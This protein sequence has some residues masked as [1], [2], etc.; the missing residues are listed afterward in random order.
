MAGELGAALSAHVR[1]LLQGLSEQNFSATAQQIMQLTDTYGPEGAVLCIRGLAGGITFAQNNA[2][3]VQLLGLLVGRLAERPSFGSVLAQGLSYAVP[4]PD[5]GFLQ[6]FCRVCKVSPQLSVQVAAALADAAESGDWRAEGERVLRE[7]LPGLNGAALASLGERPLHALLTFLRSSE[8][9]RGYLSQAIAVLQ[10]HYGRGTVPALLRPLLYEDHSHSQPSLGDWFQSGQPMSTE[11]VVA[12]L[13][14]TTDQ[15]TVIEELGYACTTSKAAFAEVLGLMPALDERALGRLVG[16][17]ARTHAELTR[18][19]VVAGSGVVGSGGS[20]ATYSLLLMALRARAPQDEPPQPSGWNLDVIVEVVKELAPTLSWARAMVDHLDQERFHLPDQGAFLTLISLYKRATSEPFPVTAVAG[21]LWQNSAGQLSLLNHAVAAPPDVFSWAQSPTKQQPLEGLHG[22]KNPAGTVNQAWLSLDLIQTLAMLAENSGMAADVRAL[23]EHPI[24]HC[25]ELLLLGIA[26]TRTEWNVLQGEVFQALVPQYLANHPNSSLVLHQLFPVNRGAVLRAM[27][28]AHAVDPTSLPRVLE[29]CQDLKQLTAVLDGAPFAFALDLASLA[30]RREYLNLEKWLSERLAAQGASFASACIQFLRSKSVPR[31]SGAGSTTAPAINLSRETLS[32]F[33]AVLSRGGML[34][35]EMQEELKIHQQQASAGNPAAGMGAGDP[36]TAAPQPEAM[37]FSPDIEEEANSFFQKVYTSQQSIAEAVEMLQVFSNGSPR[38]QEVFSCMIHNLFDE[39]R[40]FP[41]YPDKELR[42]TA[43]LF[44]S[45]INH[46]LLPNLTLGIALRYVLDALRKPVG[47]KMFVFG[48]EALEEF[49]SRLLEWPPFCQHLIAI[50]HM[51]ESHPQVVAFLERSLSTTS[52]GG[53]SDIAAVAATAAA[54]ASGGMGSAYEAPDAASIEGRSA[55][56]AFSTNPSVG[57]VQRDQG[58]PPQPPTSEMQRLG[59][60][61]GPSPHAAP[62]QPGAAAGSSDN[63]SGMTG[64]SPSRSGSAAGTSP[65]TLAGQAGVGALTPTALKLD[66]AASPAPPAPQS[67]TSVFTSLNIDTLLQAPENSHALAPGDALVDKVAFL[68]NNLSSQNLAQKAQAVRDLI[69]EEHFSWFATYLVVKRVSLEGN[70]HSLYLGLLDELSIRELNKQVLQAAYRNARILLRSDKI[71][72]S[73]AERSL[74]K[75]LGA[76][77]GNLTIAKNKPVLQR[78]LD[79]KELLFEAY[80]HGRMI[81][82]MPF[83]AKIIEPCKDSK[84]FAPPNPWLMAV[85]A[86]LAEIY[87]EK[88]LKLNLKF[89]VERLFKHLEVDLKTT[90]PS[91][92]LVHRQR[93][94]AIDNQDF[95]QEKRAA[96]AVSLRPAVVPSAAAGG[97][98]VDLQAPVGA[99]AQQ[100]AGAQQSGV[101]SQQPPQQQ[102]QQPQQPQQQSGLSPPV[103]PSGQPVAK[104]EESPAV[105]P[106]PQQQTQTTPS[107]VGYEQQ[108]LSNVQQYVITINQS[109]SVLAD[110]LQLKRLLPVALD[111]G[112]REIVS[113]VVERSVTIAC[114]TTRELVL[115]DFAVDPDEARLRKAAHL[116]VSSL[117]GS[118]ALVTCKEPLRVSVANQLR[119][120]LQQ[121]AQQ[122]GGLAGVD[123]QILDQAVQVAT[124]DNLDLG[125][126]LIEKAATEKAIHDIDEALAAAFLARRKHRAENPGQVF[127]D[128]AHFQGRFPGALPESLRPKP[129]NLSPAQQRVYDDFRC[130]PRAAAPPHQSGTPPVQPGMVPSQP[131]PPGAQPSAQQQQPPQPLAKQHPPGPRSPYEGEALKPGSATNSGDPLGSATAAALAAA[132]GQEPLGLSQVMERYN[133][134]MQRLDATLEKEPPQTAF[135]ALPA[136]HEARGIVSD[137]LETVAQASARE[138]AA[139][140][141]ANKVFERMYKRAASRL[142]VTTH[143]AILEGLRGMYKQLPKELTTLLMYLEDDLKYILDVVEGLVRAH[144]LVVPDFDAYLA[145][146]MSGDRVGVALE[147]S[148]S[149]VQ[150]CVVQETLVPAAEFS[151]V[152]DLLAKFATRQGVPEAVGQLV[153]QAR[154]I[155]RKQALEQSSTTPTGAAGPVAPGSL[156]AEADGKPVPAPKRKHAVEPDPPGLREQVAAHFDEW[157][158]VCEAPAGDAAYTT[159]VTGLHSAGLLHPPEA[160]ERFFRI[161][162]ELAIAHCLASGEAAAA[163]APPNAPP[164]PLNYAAIDAYGRLVLMLG[165]LYPEAYAMPGVPVTPQARAGVFCRGLTAMVVTLLRDSDE[166]GVA[167]N[168]RPY[169][170]LMVGWLTDLHSRDHALDSSNPQVLAMIGQALLAVQ[171]LRVPGFAFAWLE[172]VAHKC[173]MPRL[174]MDHGQKGWPLLQRLLTAVMR[175]MEPYLR[176]AELNEPIRLLYKGVLRVLL[177]LLHDFPQFL[178]DHHFHFCDAIPPSCIQMRN[179]VLSAFP[180]NMRLPDPFTPNL[181]VDLLP[182]ITQSPRIAPDSDAAL[183]GKALYTE[184]LQY[185]KTRQPTNFCADLRLRLLLPQAEALKAGTRYNVPLINA[186]VLVVGVQAI[187][188][189]GTKGQ[190]A[191]PASMDIYQGLALELDTEGRYLFLNAIANQLRFPNNHTHYFSCV[192]LKLFAEATQEIVQEQ[193][194]RVLLERLIVNRPHPWGLLITFIELIKNPRYSFWSH[195]FTR[196]APEIERLFESVARSCMGPSGRAEEETA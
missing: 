180:R 31:E 11:A 151:S 6:N 66:V 104:E 52:Q 190:S 153:D 91:Q 69:P 96:E 105:Q 85:L 10:K 131:A 2:P 42:I 34:S 38:E 102:P 60:S 22:S 125:C 186:L 161:L 176:N 115:K 192:L 124:S 26:Q 107:Q 4:R 98:S 97:A 53:G 55:A 46:Q 141:V 50:P 155:A 150:R 61:S 173:F 95:V 156:V 9:H 128:M 191:S 77:L 143:L 58:L 7:V 119:M 13:S 175:F 134:C 20:S 80:E 182:E 24:K 122:P 113:P 129:G 109:L 135:E 114:M 178:C 84:V 100:R 5:E 67:L 112:I 185:L 62:F 35:A 51:R 174:L 179:L 144:L 37:A 43:A 111:R 133:I 79:L 152:L 39:Y 158:G 162:T 63:L 196:C 165:R 160:Q 41:K 189:N 81:A 49:K 48:S 168:P 187:H 172:L 123:Q 15:A 116:M 45:L 157:A 164:P 21:K 33:I 163:Q 149:L 169:L 142:P 106:Q 76:W 195:S 127:Y 14:E 94:R 170:R 147:F 27:V 56:A 47:S 1:L 74:L 25:P 92:L 167:F 57:S 29:V 59:I 181:K 130:L 78:D 132:L 3:R 110:R 64:M 188:A 166:R 44:G 145:K 32:Q 18:D 36:V 23:L 87:S 17:V 90:P 140:S 139:L 16:T 121:L 146:L 89:E 194:T 171:P 136:E 183:R 19:G 126:A 148:A 154:A 120:L 184:V 86:L 65:I 108:G 73:T 82:V 159:F 70:F 68:C 30:A 193:I 99:Q 177:V 54:A 118:L 93:D 138:E 71:K 40:F 75:N 103:P 8:E 117:A 28:E 83:V 12:R 137:M 101:P 88:D 72:A